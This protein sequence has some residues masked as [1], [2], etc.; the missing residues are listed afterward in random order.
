[1]NKNIITINDNG[2]V[3]IPHKVEMKDYEIA[4][5]LGIT[6]PAARGKIRTLLKSGVQYEYYGCGGEIMR[7]GMIMQEVFGLDMVIAVAFQTNTYEADIFKK[8]IIRN[9]K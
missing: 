9:H 5:L 3:H 4:N 2:V 8:H 1:M 7:N 6:Y